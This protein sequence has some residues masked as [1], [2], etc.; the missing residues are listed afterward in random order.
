VSDR[1]RV[2]LG[3][4]GS[5][6]V[7]GALALVIAPRA[8]EVEDALGRVGA[9][10]FL[11]VV[12]LGLVAMVLRT[13]AWQVA[14][15]AAGGRIR[16]REAHPA[17]GV[18]YVA[19]LVSPYLG[20]AARI[21]VIRNIAPDRSPT[22]S[23]QVAAETALVVVEAAL[24]GALLLAASWTLGISLP[25][26]ILIFLGGVAA[27]AGLVIAARRFAPR[28]F[29]AGLAVARSPGTLGLVTA[30]LGGTVLVQL[31]RIGVVLDS[32]DLDTS[33]LVVI[34][35]FVASGLGAVIPIGTAAS[36]AAAPL[37]AATG[38]NSVA[39]ATAAGVLL[40]GSLMVSSVAYLGI[41]LLGSALAR[42]RDSA[43]SV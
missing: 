23:Q 41:A 37:I 11:A 30:A 31:L 1:T 3:L 18:S 42:S 13:L 27:I 43:R 26:A 2:A 14:I 20:A 9:G 25:L 24:V 33:P 35:V 17:S 6:L 22:V 19:G 12:G 16:P 7:F 34:A 5:L 38:G 32:V 21:A 15:D 29:G 10:T 28:R 40:S 39:D 36:G 8:D 4:V